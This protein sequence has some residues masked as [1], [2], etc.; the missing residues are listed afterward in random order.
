MTKQTLMT[1]RN[2]LRA[3]TGAA[4]VAA[5]VG[6]GNGLTDVN[7]NPNNP[8]DVSA[9]SL[10]T[11][12]TRQAVSRWLGVT[13]DWRGGE[14]LAQHLA[15]VQYTD[16]DTYIRL[17]RAYMTGTFDAAYYQ[18]LEDYRKV[19]G[20]GVA[21]NDPGTYA[22][23]QVMKS[24]VVDFLTDTWGDVPYTE[25]LASDSAG[26]SGKPKYDTQ[27]AIY[28]DL[29]K[30]LSD[31]SAAL[32]S[33]AS[34][35]LGSADPIYGGDPTAWAK[36]SN[37]LHAR[38]AMRLTNVDMALASSELQKAFSAPG[39]VFTSN[40]DNA[41]LP[42]PGDGVNDNPFSESLQTRD[43]YRMS[44]K[45]IAVLQGNNDPRLPIFAH[46]T[47]GGVYAGAPNG[48]EA[49]AAQPYITGASRVGTIF[50]PGATSYTTY[51]GPGATLP[52][53]LLTYAE[54]A[55]IQAEAAERGMGGLTPA[56][57][58]GFYAAGIRASME[59]WG[60]TDAAAINAYIA[61][62]SVAYQGGTAGLKQIAIQKWIALFGDGGQ[63]WFEWRRTCQP[64]TIAPGPDA[65]VDYVP[66]R[67]YYSQT[68]KS[69]NGENLA[70]A[71]ADQGGTD[72]FGTRVW[73]D[74]P[75]NA[76]TCAGVD[77]NLP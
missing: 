37:S 53:Q 35:S 21:A 64:P 45:F 65:T 31:A 19:I 12:A 18:E 40:A 20:K 59:Q 27:Q 55:F 77:L 5:L 38:L 61:Q 30:T 58:A 23:A 14:F 60:V 74:K 7:R 36:F 66:R 44:D 73:W 76:P 28:T 4:M 13:Y 10:F 51:G 33:G 3:A 42:W 11:N 9:Q 32:T 22:P 34:A 69:V 75:E 25:A 70:A 6:C 52:S 46:P 26:G 17:A 56:Q 8:T 39:G 43:D 24:W 41:M 47:D 16:E 1:N 57:A 48:I 49:P 63:A 62:P 72:N 50:F 67:F 68:E 2:L 54:V 15:E 29:F 71:V